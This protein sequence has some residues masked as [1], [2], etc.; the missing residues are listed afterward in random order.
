MIYTTDILFANNIAA[1]LG[2]QFIM[3]AFLRVSKRTVGLSTKMKIL[4]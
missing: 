2:Y 3:G 1:W 4:N